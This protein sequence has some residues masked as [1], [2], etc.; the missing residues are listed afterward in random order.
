MA[1]QRGV[2]QELDQNVR[3]R[4]KMTIEERSEAVGMS[5]GGT[6]VKEIA[7]HFWRTPQGIST[8]LKKHYHSGTTQDKPRSGRPKMISRHQSKLIYCAARKDPKIEYK[9]ILKV[10]VFVDQN[11]T[12]LKS[13][14][15]STLLLPKEAFQ[16][17]Q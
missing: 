2:L 10:A 11:G 9:K 12:P 7:D 6:A 3:R 13:P 16:P 5:V 15:C 1:T 17:K 4:P 14:S 8:L